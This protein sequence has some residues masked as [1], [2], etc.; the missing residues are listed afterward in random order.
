MVSAALL[1]LER[2]DWS[3]FRCGCGR[4]A[5]HIPEVFRKLLDAKSPEDAVGYRFDGHLEIQ[6]MLFEA[7]VPAVPVILAS[8]MEELALF[9]RSHLLVTLLFLVSG[10]SHSSELAAGREGLSGECYEKAREGLW[11]IY[12]EAVSGDTENALDILEIIE[13][14]ESRFTAFRAALQERLAKQQKGR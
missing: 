2:H 9:A 7:A 4:S 10:E 12:R 5:A 14:D 1:E 8:L 6:S 3:G 13:E 11:V